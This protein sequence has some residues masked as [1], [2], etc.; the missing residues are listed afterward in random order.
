VV[1][2][3]VGDS[4]V[5]IVVGT[6]VVG[7]IV[8]GVCVVVGACVVVVVCVVGA[9]VVVKQS[10]N[11]QVGTKVSVVVEELPLHP[12]KTIKMK[13]EIIKMVIFFMI[14]IT[15]FLIITFLL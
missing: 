2:S 8:V 7:A 14:I 4:V 5:V 13:S 6:I 1:I 9:T 12:I 15:P 3:V 10:S 11:P